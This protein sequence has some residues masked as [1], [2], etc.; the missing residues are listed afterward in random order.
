MNSVLVA[1]EPGSN[2]ETKTAPAFRTE[3]LKCTEDGEATGHKEAARF[4]CG[5]Y[6][7]L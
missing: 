7:A 6:T 4:V 1:C 3:R 2:Q 5:V